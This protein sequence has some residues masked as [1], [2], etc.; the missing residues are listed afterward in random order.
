MGGETDVTE[1]FI[2]QITNCN[3]G[4][5]LVLRVD[6]TDAYNSWIYDISIDI[7]H[8]LNRY[9]SLTH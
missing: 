2:W 6:G 7:G 4:D 8:P 1:P 3:G 5:F 9:Y